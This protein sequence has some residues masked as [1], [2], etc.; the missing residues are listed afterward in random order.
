MSDTSLVSTDAP[1]QHRWPGDENGV[2]R[3]SP[4]ETRL[5]V[6]RNLLLLGFAQSESGPVRDLILEAQALGLGALEVL[7]DDFDRI[8][9]RN[10]QRL[11]IVTDDGEFLRVTGHGAFSLLVAPSIVDLAVDTV[12]RHGRAVLSVD[13]VLHPRLLAAVTASAHRYGVSVVVVCGGARTTAS[14]PDG[15]ARDVAG[16]VVVIAAPAAEGSGP[17]GV[18]AVAGGAALLR[19][20]RHGMPTPARVYW[21]AYDRALLALAPDNDVSSRHAGPMMIDADGVVHGESFEE[22]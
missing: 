11:T 16:D 22:L 9:D 14:T 17:A 21:T 12:Y 1:S 20:A 2:M 6:E 18:S 8:R 5:V 10:G 4:R 13:D 7:A 3:L 15:D 19:A